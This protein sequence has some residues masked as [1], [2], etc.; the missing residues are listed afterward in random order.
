MTGRVSRFSAVEVRV[1]EHENQAIRAFFDHANGMGLK[2]E[3][4]EPYGPAVIGATKFL[5]FRTD[6]P[7]LEIL[8]PLFQDEPRAIII[9]GATGYRMVT[10]TTAG[11]V[12]IFAVQAARLPGY[13]RRWRGTVFKFWE[14]QFT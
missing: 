9:P 1:G 11:S 13:N 5:R 6:C 10:Q 7:S 12:P 8:L 2:F 14:R 4:L 3:F